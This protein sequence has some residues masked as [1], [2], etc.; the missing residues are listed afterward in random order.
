MYLSTEH[1]NNPMINNKSVFIIPSASICKIKLYVTFGKECTCNPR[2][3]NSLTFVVRMQ[4]ARLYSAVLN[5]FNEVILWVIQNQLCTSHLSDVSAL[6]QGMKS[7][8]FAEGT[9]TVMLS[10]PRIVI[11]KM[12]LAEPLGF[13][14]L[15]AFSLSL[16]SRFRTYSGQK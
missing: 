13:D 2:L 15:N 4:T 12:D 16:S 10:R 5:K 8:A 9:I 7:V 14:T 1:L 11:F 6:R 3:R